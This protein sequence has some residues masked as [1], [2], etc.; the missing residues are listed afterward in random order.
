MSALGGLVFDVALTGRLKLHMEPTVQ[1]FL[2]PI[3]KEGMMIGHAYPYSYSIQT[4]ISY[5]F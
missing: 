4:G 3:I 1:L 5:D 2:N